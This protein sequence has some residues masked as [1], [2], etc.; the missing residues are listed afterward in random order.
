MISCTVIISS[1]LAPIMTWN[2]LQPKKK[3][4]HEI[5]L[6][7]RLN[8]FTQNVSIIMPISNRY[9]AQIIYIL[10]KKPDDL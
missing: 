4:W 9:L 2:C 10:D 7:R 3:R 8:N 1:G 5:K 6:L